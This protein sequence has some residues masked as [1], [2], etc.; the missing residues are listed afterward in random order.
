VA[1]PLGVRY[2]QI[3]KTFHQGGQSLTV[4]SG[5]DIEVAPGEFIAL[6]GPSGSGKSTLL[7][8]TAGIDRPTSG[9]VL[10]GEQDPNAMSGDELS[11]WRRKNVGFVFQ[12]YHLLNVLTAAENVEVPLLLFKLS[13]AERQR[14]VMTALELVGL[15]DRARHSPK[16]LSGGEEQRV[17]IA[18]SII[19]DPALILADE[20]TG[21]LDTHSATEILK[22][23]VLLN[24]N[25]KKTIIMVTHDPKAAEY[26]KR[27]L[28]LNK[29]V[30]LEDPK[31]QAA[32]P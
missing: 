32:Q 26:A 18:R 2:K 11:D 4:L 1:D 19:N 13:A 16:K 23:L 30:I 15:A 21:D 7:N 5:V 3:T 17:A 20:P 12:R 31:P 29:G 22:L 25:F 14:R 28:R 10:V 27:I 9:T 24:E 8:L 6:M